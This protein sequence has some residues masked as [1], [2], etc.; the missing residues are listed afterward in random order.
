MKMNFLYTSD[1]HASRDHLFSMLR[2]AERED[3]DSI[4][5]GGDLVPHGLPE[6][7]RFGILQ[8]QGI[9]LK[10]VLIPAIRDFK[11]KKDVQIYLDLANDDFLSNRTILETYAEDHS[12]LFNLL[13]MQKHKLTNSVDI[14]GYMVVPPTPFAIKDWEKPDSKE[15]PSV[16]DNRINLKGY[17]SGSGKLEEIKLDLRSDDTIENDLYRISKTITGP[18]IFVAHSPPYN[19]PLDTLF[20]GG[21]VGS[22]SI[23]RFVEKWSRSG[24]L[25]ASFH[26]HI[27]ESAVKSGSISTIIENSLCVNPGQGSGDGAKFQYVICDLW[28]DGNIPAI[29]LL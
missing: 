27:H 9:Y 5:I 12:G 26:G 21:H 7:Q 18:F 11:Q 10:D 2:I 15:C 3:V 4:I 19:T 25:L 1:I 8:A 29:K 6:I 17:I 13:H 24:E 20:N 28:D 16:Q 22:I 23:R 14:I